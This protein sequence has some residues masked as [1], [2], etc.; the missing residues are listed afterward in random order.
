MQIIR[1]PRKKLLP[2]PFITPV[3]GEWGP[4]A[5][6]GCYSKLTEAHIPP[7]SVGNTNEWVT[8]SYMTALT[9][10]NED[11]FFP[12]HFKGGLKFKTLCAEC[13]SRLGGRED[14]AL[15]NF[16]D[17]VRKLTESPIILGTPVIKVVGQPNLIFRGLLAHLTSAN[18]SGMPCIFDD[19][20]RQI[21]FNKRPLRQSSWNLFYWLYLGTNLF[22]TRNVFYMTWH[23]TVEVSP[24]FLLKLYPLAFLLSHDSWFMGCPNIR[25]FVCPRDEDET[26][27]PIQVLRYDVDPFWPATPSNRNV[28]MGGGNTFGLLGSKR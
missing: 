27:L 7:Q 8:R 20:A 17:Q 9:S 25:K 28:I 21:F 26:E 12:R 13:N 5:L 2:D 10:R 24:M 18:D 15:Q 22:V 19:E 14:K 3:P 11:V 16:F 6:C 4:C 1:L 23:P